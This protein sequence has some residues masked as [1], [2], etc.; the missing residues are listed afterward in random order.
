[1]IGCWTNRNNTNIWTWMFKRIWL[2]VK[3]FHNY[4]TGKK[5]HVFGHNKWKEKQMT[6]WLLGEIVNVAGCIH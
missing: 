3:Q 1:M 5:L 4:S 6:V 2:Q